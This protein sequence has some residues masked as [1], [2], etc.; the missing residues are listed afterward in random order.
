MAGNRLRRHPFRPFPQ[1]V[2]MTAHPPPIPP[3]QRNPHEGDA[4]VAPDEAKAPR[5]QAPSENVRQNTTNK[6]F[7]QDR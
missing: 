1:E 3:E 5:D 7:Q 2:D 4:H 6:G